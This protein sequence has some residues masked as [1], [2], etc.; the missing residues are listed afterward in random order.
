MSPI[1][2]ALYALALALT[3]GCP[4]LLLVNSAQQRRPFQLPPPQHRMAEP[5]RLALRAPLLLAVVG[6]AAYLAVI[7]Q[8]GV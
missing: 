6:A 4:A 1:L 2:L 3:L 8:I 5:S 7:V